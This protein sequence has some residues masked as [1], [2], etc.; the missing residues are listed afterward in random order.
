MSSGKL[1]FMSPE[2]YFVSDDDFAD[3]TPPVAKKQ[4]LSNKENKLKK[5]D[6]VTKEVKSSRYATVI[7]Y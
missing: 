1:V 3:S 5:T 7:Q 2:N 6:T 4:K